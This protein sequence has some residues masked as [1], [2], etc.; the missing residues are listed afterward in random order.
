MKPQKAGNRVPAG[1]WQ[2]SEEIKAMEGSPQKYRSNK[3]NAL[4]P[5]ELKQPFVSGRLEVAYV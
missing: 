3:G 4:H 5:Q 2:G 1:S